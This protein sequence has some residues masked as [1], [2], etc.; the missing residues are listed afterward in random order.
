MVACLRSA[1]ASTTRRAGPR[2]PVAP[3]SRWAAT[4]G[5]ARR[6]A[7]HR[8]RWPSRCCRWPPT[9]ASAARAARHPEPVEAAGRQGCQAGASPRPAARA[10]GGALKRSAGRGLTC[11]CCPTVCSGREGAQI[12]TAV[13]AAES[14]GI[15][16]PTKGRRAVM[17][18]PV[19]GASARRGGGRRRS[20]GQADTRVTAAS[21][22]PSSP[23]AESSSMGNTA[24]IVP[25]RS[26]ACTRARNTPRRALSAG[27]AQGRGRR[28]SR[29][30]GARAPARHVAWNCPSGWRSAAGSPACAP[31]RSK[32]AAAARTPSRRAARGDAHAPR[33]AARIPRHKCGCRE[34]REKGEPRTSARSRSLSS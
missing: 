7:Q 29:G 18:A 24:S 8:A 1:R 32:S 33:V 34:G 12:P 19:P 4:L 17:Q 26:T 2:A 30:G 31:R 6:A 23:L 27:R 10:H 25:A 13:L 5:A 28:G 14:C 9:A 20:I 22:Q 16:M 21:R 11:S 3:G 15:A